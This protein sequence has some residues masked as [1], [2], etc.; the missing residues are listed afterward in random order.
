MS[1]LV[2]W[3]LCSLWQELAREMF[4]SVPVPVWRKILP[5]IVNNMDVHPRRVMFLTLLT[6]TVPER[7]QL[8]GQLVYEGVTQ[9]MW[10][11]IAAD[12]PAIIPRTV[13]GNWHLY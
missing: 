13:A 4:Q 9:V 2:V 12:V 11:R 10:D 5:F 3:V 8:I 6:S 7:A 1:G